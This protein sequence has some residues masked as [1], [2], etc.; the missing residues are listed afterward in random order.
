M[1]YLE[2]VAALCKALPQLLTMIQSFMG[3][4]TKVS[5]NDPAGFIVRAGSAF[6]QLS[7]AQTQEEHQNAAKALA[8]LVRNLPAK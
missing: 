3:W 2:A 5:G 1:G 4:L 6:D 7:K 8:D